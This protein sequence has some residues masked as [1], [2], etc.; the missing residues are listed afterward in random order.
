MQENKA[1]ILRVTEELLGK[2]NLAIIDEVAAPTFVNHHPGSGQDRDGL[3]AF[4]AALFA[5]VPVL[6]YTIEHVVAEGDLVALHL[7]GRGTQVGELFGAP[8]TGQPFANES[9]TINRIAEGKIVERW[10]VASAFQKT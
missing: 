3:K 9:I 6:E 7:R 8:P 1:L 2:R 10:Y 5:V 4:L